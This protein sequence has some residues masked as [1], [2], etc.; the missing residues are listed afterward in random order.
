MKG[1]GGANKIIY[2]NIVAQ[3]IKEPP[4]Y[5]TVGTKNSKL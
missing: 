5:V 1:N 4:L 3:T 2:Y